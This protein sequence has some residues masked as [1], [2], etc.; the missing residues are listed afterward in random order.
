MAGLTATTA[1]NAALLNDFEIVSTAITAMVV[2]R[3]APGP[4]YLAALAIMLA[5]TCF[6]ATDGER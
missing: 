5:G 1:A 3:E 2:F 4:T 6:A